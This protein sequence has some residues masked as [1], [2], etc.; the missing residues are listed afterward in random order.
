[1]S[2]SKTST[3]RISKP[4]KLPVEEGFESEKIISLKNKRKSYIGELTK[5][6]NLITDLIDKKAE[7][8]SIENCD[9][10]LENI[11]KNVRQLTTELTQSESNDAIIQTEL[12]ICTEQEFR[13]IQ[14]R[15]AISSHVENQNS[16]PINLNKENFNQSVFE[17]DFQQD[18]SRLQ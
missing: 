8:S 16:S 10:S 14:I 15:N 1:M 12:N 3:K 6:I 2:S 7:L 9:K 18:S 11:I 13:V 17:A 5:T 4:R